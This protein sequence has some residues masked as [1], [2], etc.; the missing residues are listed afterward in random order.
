MGHPEFFGKDHAPGD[1]FGASSV[2]DF[3]GMAS[4]HLRKETD[5]ET[6]F[7]CAGGIGILRE[8][9]WVNAA[10]EV[11]QYNLAFL[12]PHRQ[13]ADNGRILGFDNAHGRHERHWLGHAMPF[14][15]I[16]Y[17]ATARRFYGEVEAIRRKYENENLRRRL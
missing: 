17:D 4:R 6:R 2:V 11:V 3:L 12:L 7:R 9:V 10:R 8:E 15:F 5:Y 13:R 1:A 14:N 16:D